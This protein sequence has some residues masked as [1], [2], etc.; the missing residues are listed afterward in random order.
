MGVAYPRPWKIL[1]SC[2]EETNDPPDS[3][4]GSMTVSTQPG[5]LENAWSTT[6]YPG[7]EPPP[8]AIAPELF[9]HSAH[10]IDSADLSGNQFASFVTQSV[11]A[12]SIQ[13]LLT[14]S[15]LLPILC[16]DQSMRSSRR[17]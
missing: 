4:I 8:F 10:I 9:L 11:S 5:R 3:Q 6:C 16:H 15:N 2:H 14:R 1:R 13:F 12:Q 17:G 7:Q